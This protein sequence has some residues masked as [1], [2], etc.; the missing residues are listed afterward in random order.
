MKWLRHLVNLKVLRLSRI[1][2]DLSQATSPGKKFGEY[3]SYLSNLTDLD[4]SGCYITNSGFLTKIFENQ[5][6][7]LQN[8]WID[9]T[10]VEGP[11]PMTISNAP[12]LV[13][14]SASSCSI[15]GS[16]PSSFYNLSQLQFLDLSGND[17]T[18][19]I[20]SSISHLRNLYSLD[21]SGNNFQGSIPTSISNL[22]NLHFL[23]LSGNN[24][25]GSIP[26][27][28]SKLKNLHSLCLSFNNFQGSIPISISYLRNLHFLDLSYNNFQGSIPIS[29]SYL[30]N[31]HFLDLSYNNFQGSIPKSICEIYT[32]QELSLYHNNISGKIPSCITK[33]RHLS[34]F[35][36][37]N[38]SINGTVPL[39]SW[40]NELNLT[41][42]DLSSNR[43]TVMI[44]QRYPLSQFT[45]QRLALLL[46]DMKRS[47]PTFIFNL[48]H[49]E[50][51]DLNDTDL[52]GDSNPCMCKLENVG[53][54]HPQNYGLVCRP[55]PPPGPQL[56]PSQPPPQYIYAI[57]NVLFYG[58]VALGFIV[59]FWGLFFGLLIKKEKW[60]CGYW[61]FVDTVATKIV[62]ECRQ[63][64]HVCNCKEINV[65]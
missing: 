27:S 60:W 51:L 32:L 2:V 64:I 48:T 42:L 5:W 50:Y 6:P 20:H 25:Q 34:N 45:L 55:Q 65:G 11:I 17:I 59:G 1:K 8:L 35:D 62:R 21:L 63:L 10:R 28:I 23:H 22:R 19:H 38:N 12:Q 15:Q 61:R 4:L 37:F 29:I 39:L 24:F 36:V 7:K 54:Y 52:Y 49:R 30:R 31:L 3:T 18:G 43:L 47:L 41:H 13:R 53:L 46:C 44:D 14:L 33:L 57:E 16:L 58:D 56:P 9:E 26:T 40:I